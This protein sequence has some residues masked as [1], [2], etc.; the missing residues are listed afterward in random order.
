MSNTDDSGGVRTCMQGEGDCD[1][2]C[3]SLL[4]LRLVRAPFPVFNF[5]FPFIFNFVV[6]LASSRLLLLRCGSLFRDSAFHLLGGGARSL[7]TAA[8]RAAQRKQNLVHLLLLV[9]SLLNVHEVE[10]GLHSVR[11]N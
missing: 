5:L 6:I 9:C 8:L 7:A 11:T 1:C 4:L 10:Q 3:S 2:D